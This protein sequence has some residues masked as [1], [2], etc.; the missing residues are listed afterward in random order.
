MKHIYFL[1]FF[2]CSIYTNAQVVTTKPA[3]PT[4]DASV[5]IVF[6][7]SKGNAGLNNY[8]G[9]IYA[10]IG[11]TLNGEKWQKAPTWGDNDAKYKLTKVQG[12]SNKYELKIEPSIKA[13]F[14]VNASDKITQLCMV[15]RSGDKS[16]EGKGEGGSDIFV[17]V[18]EAGLNLKI[19]TPEP[20]KFYN[21]NDEI[22]TSASATDAEKIELF[23]NDNL[24]KTV[25]ENEISHTFTATEAINYKIK[26]KATKGETTK[27]EITQVLVK[28]ATIVQDV[29]A[30]MIDGINYIDENTVT[31]V[32]FAPQK[33]SV[34]LLGD[35]NNWALDNN[36]QLKKSTDGNR[37]WITLT[38]LESGKEYG[39]QYLVDEKIKIADPYADKY[40]DP[41]NDK[42]IPAETYPNIKE[43]PLEKTDD[44]VSVFQTNQSQY[45]WTVTDFTVP[46]NE[47]L[48]IYEL[49]LRDF[50]K[51]PENK[52][53]NL[54]KALEKLDYIQKLGVNA[55]ELMPFNEFEGNNSW[56]YNPS[57]YFAPDKAYGT[58][59]DYKKFID[60]CHKRGIAVFMDMV[61]NHAFGQSPLVKLYLDKYADNEIKMK[62]NPWFNAQSPNRS[63]YWGAD[64][65]HESAETQKLVDRINKYWIEEYKIDGF[66]FDFTKGFTNKSGDGWA[67]D[68]SRIA[69]LKRMYDEIKN[70]KSDAVVILEHLADNSEEKILAEHGMLLWGNFN[71]NYS[72]AAKG[73]NDDNKSNFS[74]I[75]YKVKGW[76]KP[77]LVGYM[78]SHDEERV[79][80]ECLQNGK[81]G[82]SY[83]T[84]NLPTALKKS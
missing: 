71:K 42:H 5:T 17:N 81:S 82:W 48:I 20:N 6:D 59:N 32:L 38:G 40:L 73:E 37:Y 56:G 84:K 14:G 44:I 27:E 33:Q 75:S 31:L 66:R 83:G 9:E 11:V 72:S 63:Y 80:Y 10:H 61:L 15:F 12:E 64:F 19:N 4:P 21:L 46:K 34:Y 52:E 18:F 24:V 54:K 74:G 25:T 50:T 49:H 60:E 35:F 1:L 2:M 69:I 51:G 3:I 53:G 28:S 70:V 36:Y 55:I 65:N 76:T 16:K 62:T 29:P 23:I 13:Y 43:Y 57:F 79:M 41:W 47:K 68:D 39:F 58:K 77:N 8:T 22:T 30:N 67:K 7:A 45:N 78:E 26:Y